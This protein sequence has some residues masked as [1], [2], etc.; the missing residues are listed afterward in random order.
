MTTLLENY[1]SNQKILNQK[2]ANFLWCSAEKVILLNGA[3]QAYPILVE[4]FSGKKVLMPEP[5]FGEYPSRFKGDTYSDRP[6]YSLDDIEGEIKSCDVVII[7][8]PNNPSGFC[9]KTNN[10]YELA[11]QYPGKIFLIDESFIDFSS[12]PSI[13]GLL[14]KNPL[15]NVIVIKSFSKCLGVPGL[16][17][18]FVYSS[19]PSFINFFSARIPVWNINSLC[20]FFL[21]LILKHRSSLERS[22]EMTRDDR[23]SL[24][25]ELSLLDCV[26]EVFSGEGN[27]IL[28][29]LKES[30][31]CKD[32]CRHMLE[33]HSIYLKDVSK[34]FPDSRTYV[35]IAVRKATDNRVLIDAMKALK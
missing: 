21:E 29:R 4:Y 31:A 9:C 28:M 27:F 7:V 33:K 23:R 26:D 20:E 32:F 14:E 22:F 10:I 1:C 13:V 12:E 8:N 18:G 3:S 17:L 16:R 35:R 30:D 19:D 11:A 5:T 24:E 2:I 34:K 25:K 6:G 15:N